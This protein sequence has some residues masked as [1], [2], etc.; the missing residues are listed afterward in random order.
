MEVPIGERKSITG[1]W[2]LV[3]AFAVLLALFQRPSRQRHPH[4][5]QDSS[6]ASKRSGSTQRLWGDALAA[7]L[8]GG[9]IAGAVLLAERNRTMELANQVEVL[10]NT[11][12]ARQ[13]AIEVPSGPKPLT[14]V[15]LAGAPLNSLN[16]TRADL[17]QANL[18]GADLREAKL[19][20]A[21]L[22]GADLTGA[23][24]EEADLAGADLREAVLNDSDMHLAVLVGTNLSGASLIDSTLT[25][26]NLTSAFMAEGILD[27]G[28]SDRLSEGVFIGDANLTGANLTAVCWSKDD[29]PTWP[30]SYDAPPQR[31]C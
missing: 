12:F 10:E 15:N 31:D 14:R 20:G 24:L 11:R 28:P 25:G 23:D 13:L 1:S 5:A 22:R 18:T 2:I 9:L 4:Q 8:V 29:P 3:A 30:H 19:I 26:A 21:D 17:R 6:A 27:L 7:L 16:L